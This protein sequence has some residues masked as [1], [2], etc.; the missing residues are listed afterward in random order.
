M[1]I[2][3][4]AYRAPSTPDAAAIFRYLNESFRTR[5]VNFASNHALHSR[6]NFS[7]S[8]PTKAPQ[9]KRPHLLVQLSPATLLFSTPLPPLA[10]RRSPRLSHELL[11]LLFSPF[12]AQDRLLAPVSSSTREGGNWWDPLFENHFSAPSLLGNLSLA[13]FCSARGLKTR[14]KLQ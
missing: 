6:A 1:A 12:L 10:P 8:N 11:L 4:R 3:R 13:P 2:I 14:K 5:G 9:R 7:Q